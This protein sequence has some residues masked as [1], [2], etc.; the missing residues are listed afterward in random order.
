[1][2]KVLSATEMREVD[3][4]TTEKYGIPSIL[5]ME[6]AAHA[7]ARVI[8]EK[9][10]GSVAGKSFL[11]LCGKG[12]NGGDGAALARILWTLGADCFVYL[13]G[14]VEETKGEARVNFEI[15]EKYWKEP[16][17]G[18][19]NSVLVFEQ[20][21]PT[22]EQISKIIY[23]A[24]LRR[25]RDVIVD[26]LFGTGLDK[27]LQGKIE[28]LALCQHNHQK[29]LAFA[30]KPLAVSIDIPS[31][32]NADLSDLIG[33]NIQAD[34][35]ITFI[36]PKLA[37]VFPPASNSNGELVVA[38]IGSPQELIDN[39]PSQT[40]VA[41]KQDAQ[42]WLNKTRV[43]PDS[44]KKTRGTAL[45][46]AGSKSY[47]GAACLTANACFA[48]GAGMVS[49]AVPKSVQEIV[50]AKVL[51]EVIT[52]GFSE[53]KNGAF[54]KS[55]AKDIL[56]L[57][58]KFDV[59]AIGCGLTS[60]EES[61]RKFV[62]EVVEKR[63]TPLVIDADGLNA[64]APFDLKGSDKLPLVLTP[65]IGE[66]QRLIGKNKITDRIKTAREFAKKH[67]VI[68]LLKGERSLV[69][70]PDG[71]VVINPTGNAGISRAGAG[72]TLTGIITSFLAQT[73]ALE[74]PNLENTLETVVAALYISSLAGNIAAEKFGQRLMTATDIR[75]C[76]G[77]AIKAITN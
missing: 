29:D 13:F 32:L 55:A 77:E 15:L 56:E 37:N 6:N 18:L 28:N 61:T 48:A 39:S 42:N 49:V 45:I 25:E 53:T 27:S 23:F 7:A 36:A 22:E 38:D 11:I 73:F 64:L 40:F 21:E 20:Y 35:T 8:T 68:L 2:Q 60:G 75:E 4:R 47:S 9:L 3:R 31:G 69:A 5:L 59:A 63:Q 51:D 1:M 58:E 16:E 65:H 57:S 43:K 54:A 14:K 10:G 70:A 62:R 33:E 66:F 17:T 74:K 44:Y 67:N 12:N 46:I 26:A 76:L 34:L 72:D 19:N 52:R 30:Q 71:R 50:A 41:E 24:Y